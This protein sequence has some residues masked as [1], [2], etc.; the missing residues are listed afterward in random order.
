MNKKF[1]G[2]LGVIMIAM[3]LSMF[4]ITYAQSD[5]VKIN[6]SSELFSN[7][8]LNNLSEASNINDYTGDFA[9]DKSGSVQFRTSVMKLVGFL[10][11]LL[12]PIVILLLVYG[13]VELYLVH[14][15]EETYNKTISQ[16][17][18]IGT[19]F[20][21]MMVA[22]NIVDWIF[23][24]KQG[25]IFSGDVDPTEFAQRGMAEITGL[26][27][28][29]TIFA[30]IIAVLFIIYNAITLIVA[31]GN[32]ETQIADVK[33]RI[34]FAIVGIIIMISVKPMI[35][36][37]TDGSGGLKM[38]DILGGIKIVSDWVNFIL[39]LIGVFAV[40]SIIYAGVR[41][42]I[43]FGDDEATTQAKN[44]IVAALIGLVLTFSSWTIIHYF[45]APV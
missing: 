28:Y 3:G 30:V 6:P 10:K 38:P 4:S 29:L 14:G 43:N 37:I 5:V 34:I 27:D 21:L 1:R 33:E 7:G 20:L 2:I 13:G 31:G 44:I 11:R 9:E 35:E 16:I 15:N 24:G 45:I 36:L 26:F 41:L 23:F 39:G 12:G 18:G 32:D 40:M 25:E 19:G 17:A 8:G 22:V 42:V